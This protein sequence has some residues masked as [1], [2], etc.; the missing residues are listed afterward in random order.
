[1]LRLEAPNGFAKQRLEDR[2]S[3][4]E[5]ICSGFFGEPTRIEVAEV[6][7]APP[8]GPA[9]RGEDTRRLKQEA[10]NNPLVNSA[11][12]ILQADIVEIRPVSGRGGSG[13]NA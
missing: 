6:K 13:G 9:V 12:E 8:A 1:V 5:S 10:L 3:D 11:L 4:L 2:A 7:Q